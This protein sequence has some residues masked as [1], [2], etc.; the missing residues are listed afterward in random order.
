LLPE[1]SVFKIASSRLAEIGLPHY[2]LGH[3]TQCSLR[4]NLNGLGSLRSKLNS[5]G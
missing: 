1:V 5:L 3:S 4:S 2:E